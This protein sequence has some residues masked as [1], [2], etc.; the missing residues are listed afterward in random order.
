MRFPLP[1]GEAPTFARTMD[2]RLLNTVANHPDV[3]PWLGGE[4][5]IDLTGALANPSTIAGVTAHGGFVCLAQ[6][7]GR[8]EVHSLFL[9]GRPRGEA[10]R[11]MRDAIAYF[12]AATDGVELVTKVPL[13][14]RAAR[15]LA[16]LAGFEPLWTGA[17]TW[18]PG[19]TV[20]TEYLRLSIDRWAL[21]SDQARALGTWLHQAFDAVKAT[22]GSALE[23]HSDADDAHDRMAGAA[24]LMVRAG[25]A[26]K[27]VEFYNRWAAFA[28]YPGIRLLR[29]HPVVL[30]LEGLIVEA[31][32]DAMEVLACQ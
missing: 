7:G 20:A 22:V 5:P 18:R 9:P 21:R 31:C 4:G 27:A 13:E 1:A 11:A 28:G 17:C 16:L 2:A 29:A 24:V 8:Y 3:R 25:N 32:G 10:V 30:D 15:G 26:A 12:F 23:A 14:N 19:D 6:G